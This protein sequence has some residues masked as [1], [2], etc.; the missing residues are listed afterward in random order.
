MVREFCRE[1]DPWAFE[2]FPW[3]SRG[4]ARL[5]Q[6]DT[7]EFGKALWESGADAAHSRAFPASSHTPGKKEAHQVLAV[8]LQLAAD[9]DH[10]KRV[11]TTIGRGTAMRVLRWWPRLLSAPWAAFGNHLSSRAAAHG[12][13][14]A[15][16]DL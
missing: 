6:T 7:V 9:A 12:L 3:R 15:G 1:E 13:L 16:P 5:P 2:P 10:W 11:V 14:R 8:T 4:R